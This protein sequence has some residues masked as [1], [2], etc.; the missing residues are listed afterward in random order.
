M[1][2]RLYIALLFFG[3]LV[4]PANLLASAVKVCSVKAKITQIIPNHT[5]D[6]HLRILEIEVLEAKYAGGHS[7]G[8]TCDKEN[9]SLEKNISF[10][11][12]KNPNFRIGQIIQ[13]SHK[14]VYN[15]DSSNRN[16]ST[17]WIWEE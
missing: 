7:A 11:T 14:T 1:Q 6:P 9:Y 13:L 8:T 10:R 4:L 3:V 12:K 2:K 15:Y 16:V 17:S 5:D